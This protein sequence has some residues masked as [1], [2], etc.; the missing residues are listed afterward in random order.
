MQKIDNI[1]IKNFKSI[2]HQKIEGCKRINVFIGYPNVGKSNI[3][4]A[5]GGFSFIQG[6]SE[7]PL[8]SILRIQKFP[9]LFFDGNT[10][11]L[12]EVTLNG[13][14]VLR[15]KADGIHKLSFSCSEVDPE[16]NENEIYKSSLQD[17]VNTSTGETESLIREIYWFFVKKYNFSKSIHGAEKIS[18]NFLSFPTGQNLYD[19]LNFNRE[20][21]SE[22]SELFK[23]YNLSLAFDRATKELKILKKISETEDIFLLS[24]NQIAD[25]LQRLIFYKAAVLSNKNSVLLFEEPEAH[26]FPPYISKFTSDVM[27]DGNDNQFFITTHSPFVINDLM[28][29]LQKE[30]YAIYAVGYNKENGE[31]IIRKISDEEINEIYQYGIDLFFNLENY[32]KDVV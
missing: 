28:E 12:I 14:Q 26:M 6:G 18:S 32:L 23:Q 17:S 3:L 13:Q 30:D 20:L 2:R 8:D 9:E 19:I 15:I 22:I 25:T 21:K 5:L 4:E 16:K 31:T 24:Y 29:N 10:Y 27:Y 11:E 1:E 7:L